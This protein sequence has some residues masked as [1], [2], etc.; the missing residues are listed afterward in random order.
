MNIKIINLK[1]VFALIVGIFLMSTNFT[2]VVAEYYKE[3]SGP[4]GEWSRGS[5]IGSVTTRTLFES[6]NSCGQY[7]DPEVS[8]SNSYLKL[9]VVSPFGDVL[10]S[11]TK[12]FK[13]CKGCDQFNDIIQ[14]DYQG[15]SRD[16]SCGSDK[17]LYCT[18]GGLYKT[19]TELEIGVPNSAN[20]CGKDLNEPC[21]IKIERD[22]YYC[23]TT[24]DLYKLVKIPSDWKEANLL[25]YCN[26]GAQAG[27]SKL[28]DI[29]FDFLSNIVNSYKVCIVKNQDLSDDNT[30][31]YGLEYGLP[32][33]KSTNIYIQPNVRAKVETVFNTELMSGTIVTQ[34][35]TGTY[36]GLN[37]NFKIIE[38]KDEF[39]KEYRF[40]YNNLTYEF[41]LYNKGLDLDTPLTD[42]Y[43]LD[44]VSSSNVTRSIIVKN[45]EDGEKI[46]G[47]DISGAEMEIPSRLPIYYINNIGF[48]QQETCMTHLGK[49]G[50]VIPTGVVSNT[51]GCLDTGLIEINS[52]GFT[53]SKNEPFNIYKNIVFGYK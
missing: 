48:R 20:G 32:E 40:E 14:L 16:F 9:S 52:N 45:K 49:Y 7:V 29:N 10:T 43:D 50:A 3:P 11:H 8:G 13:T 4:G 26:D 21:D 35:G 22:L 18:V 46:I 34:L 19:V 24:K 36:K 37:G 25:V 23:K 6:D 27:Y 15:F 31:I 5:S 2:I 41:V 44:E 38:Y 39:D 1:V 42:Y 33:I 30:I 28:G 53:S 17:E 51:I 47:Y 12:R